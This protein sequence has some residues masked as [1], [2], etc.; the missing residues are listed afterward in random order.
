MLP[1]GG[2]SA[3]QMVFGSNPVDMFGWGCGGEDLTFAQDTFLAGQF[4]QQWRLRVTAQEATLK[5]AW[6]TQ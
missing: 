2:S 6:A 3:N 4:V 1:A 5:E